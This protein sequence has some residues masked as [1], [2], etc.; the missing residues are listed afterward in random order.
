MHFSLHFRQRPWFGSGCQKEVYGIFPIPVGINRVGPCLRRTT[1]R[2]GDT[3]GVFNGGC[4]ADLWAAFLQWALGANP[5]D[6]KNNRISIFILLTILLA[7]VRPNVILAGPPLL[8]AAF[9]GNVT[10]D[11]EPAVNADLVV[12]AA[13]DGLEYARGN[14]I[15]NEGAWVY[16]V[17]VPADD[18]A[19]EAVDG[20]RSGD[21]VTFSIDGEILGTAPWQGGSN[22][23]V[24]LSLTGEPAAAAAESPDTLAWLPWL[25]VVVALLLV[26]AVWFLFIRPRR[27]TAD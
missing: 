18:P 16:T 1:F 22:T 24:D 2:V 19:T 12:I 15:S 4:S 27:R 21:T 6:M 11:N 20:G 3:S 25:L 14:V 23:Q 7:F 5:I 17:K 8:P 9:Y 10:A 26:F 13:I